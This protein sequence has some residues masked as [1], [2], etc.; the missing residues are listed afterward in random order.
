MKHDDDILRT[1]LVELLVLIK[2]RG[3]RS[4][5]VREFV[6]KNKQVPEFPEL[7]ATSIFLAERPRPITRPVARSVKAH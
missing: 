5:M 6:E 4:N 3:P 1:L 7:A 2:E